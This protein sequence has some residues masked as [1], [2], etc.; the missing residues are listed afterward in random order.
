M[1]EESD[2]NKRLIGEGLL[3][4]K[5]DSCGGIRERKIRR[6]RFSS[7]TIVP[8][9]ST[10]QLLCVFNALDAALVYPI[11]YVRGLCTGV[12]FNK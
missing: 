7:V 1:T 9:H 10:G 4:W 12:G 2:L 8:Q 3:V 6:F 5:A 11:S